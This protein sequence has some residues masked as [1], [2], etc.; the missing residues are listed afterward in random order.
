MES[1]IIY[2]IDKLKF[3][4]ILRDTSIPSGAKLVLHNLLYRAKIN[5]FAFPS[6]KRI[7]FDVGLTERQVRNHLSLLNN[8]GIVPWSRGGINP[9]NGGKFNS[10]RYDLS[11]I[12]R[13]IET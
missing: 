1:K 13:R 3:E 2:R 10:N 9:K 4:A 6:Q 8:K 7:A 5:S 11:K 12:M